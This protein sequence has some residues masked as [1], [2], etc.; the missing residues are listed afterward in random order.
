P[1]P[2]RPRRRFFRFWPLFAGLFVL[3]TVVTLAAVAGT[4]LRPGYGCL[5]YSESE[6]SQYTLADVHTWR[7]EAAG[8]AIPPHSPI[9]GLRRPSPDSRY[10]AYLDATRAEQELSIAE[11]SS[12]KIVFFKKSA[13]LDFGW[14]PDGTRMAYVWRDDPNDGQNSLHVVI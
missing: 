7:I 8:L 11:R 14:S 13:W 5:Q 4:R 10:V 6:A 1:T 3:A 2:D 12:G 9:S